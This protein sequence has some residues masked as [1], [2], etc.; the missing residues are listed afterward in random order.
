MQLGIV[1]CLE[2]AAQFSPSSRDLRCRW[3]GLLGPIYNPQAKLQSASFK[4]IQKYE[5]YYIPNHIAVMQALKL[6]PYK[7]F[8]FS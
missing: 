1:T 6:E 7:T 2:K 5:N 4:S 3:Y 8:L